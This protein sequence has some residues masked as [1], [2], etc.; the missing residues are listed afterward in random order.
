MSTTATI[1]DNGSSSDAEDVSESA[2]YEEGAD[3]T[4]VVV[5]GGGAAGTA[6]AQ[7]KTRVVT[8]QQDEIDYSTIALSGALGMTPGAILG[9]A[10]GT[11]K[12]ITSNIADLAP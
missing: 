7:E 4:T 10:I 8:D 9:G 11:K 5:D 2:S 6:A 3:D 12:A 1:G